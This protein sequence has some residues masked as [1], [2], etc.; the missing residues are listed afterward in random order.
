MCFGVLLKHF[1]FFFFVSLLIF[2]SFTYFWVGLPGVYIP[3][4]SLRCVALQEAFSVYFYACQTYILLLCVPS[5]HLPSSF[6]GVSW[7]PAV[8]LCLPLPAFTS[9]HLHVLFSYSL[10]LWLSVL[11][12]VSLGFYAMPVSGLTT[13]LC[14]LPACTC[15]VLVV[16]LLGEAAWEN[17]STV[18]GG[19]AAGRLEG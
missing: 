7:V 18:E 3:R 5:L 8:P 14:H 1:F 11:H 4:C 19:W 17:I 13:T 9:Q 10:L 2:V 16:G 6:C 12:S 15:W